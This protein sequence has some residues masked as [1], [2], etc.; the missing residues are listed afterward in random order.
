MVPYHAPGSQE[1]ADAVTEQAREHRA[2]LMANHGFAVVGRDFEDAVMNA[3]EFEENARLL[4]MTRGVPVNLLGERD[5]AA[6]K[7]RF[8]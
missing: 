8:G 6:L 2:V 7:E 3:E 4:V 5:I 1:L